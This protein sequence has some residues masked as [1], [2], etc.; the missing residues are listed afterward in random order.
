MP[1]RLTTH[2]EIKRGYL[3][4]RSDDYTSQENPYFT[5]SERIVDKIKITQITAKAI[6]NILV[7]RLS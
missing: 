3:A 4:P 6:C 2:H 1:F 7:R 5:V